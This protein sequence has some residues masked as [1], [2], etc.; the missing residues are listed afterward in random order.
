MDPSTVDQAQ[1][2]HM[3]AAMV[4]V[5]GFFV[6]VVYVLIIIPFWFAF[7]KAGLS[8][9]LSLLTLIPGIGF[10]LTLYILAFARWRVVPM[11]P[12]YPAYPAPGGY[13]QQGYP[14]PAGYV[15]QQGYAASQA[16]VYPPSA[17]TAEPPREV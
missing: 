3:M 12:E 8:P 13:V 2:Q 16:P 17:P 11:A 4:P 1:V 15:P 7:K 5:I 9:W 14:P 10:L 6:L